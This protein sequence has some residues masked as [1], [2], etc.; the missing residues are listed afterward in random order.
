MS[1]LLAVLTAAVNDACHHA[2]GRAGAV[3]SGGID[4][5]TVVTLARVCGHDLPTFTGYYDEGEAFDERG[6]ARLAAGREHHEIR[7]TP[8]DIVEHFDGMMRAFRPPFQGPGAMGQ[9]I[10]AK[11]ASSYVDT[12]LS[13]EGGDELFGG[14]ARLMKVAE[15]P[16]PDGYEDYRLPDGYPRTLEDAL[17]YDLARLPDLLAVDEQSCGAWGLRSVAPMTDDRVVDHV[18]AL[19]ARDRV[20]KKLLRSAMRGLVDDRILDRT[21]KKGMPAPFVMWGQGPL[22]EFFMDRIG[23]LP[24]PARPWDRQWWYDLTAPWAPGEM[25]AAA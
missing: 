12:V 13:G 21:D 11:Y 19:P 9:Y 14:Y 10:V 1:R 7:I 16:L 23:Y 6:Y 20:G 8:E 4:S 3:L 24:D 18:L 22:K 25:E 5:S 15:H 17:A 2:E